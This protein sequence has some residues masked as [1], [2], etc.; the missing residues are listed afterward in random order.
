M[1]QT[2]KTRILAFGIGIRCDREETYLLLRVGW[3]QMIKTLN[4][5]HGYAFLTISLSGEMRG[6]QREQL[7]KSIVS[8]LSL[9]KRRAKL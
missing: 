3:E 6:D 1:K 2:K 5:L 4:Y 9:N 7:H 8:S